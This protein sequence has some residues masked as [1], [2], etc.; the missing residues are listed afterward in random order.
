MRIFIVVL[1]ATLNVPAVADDHQKDK[2][3]Q[4]EENKVCF[5]GYKDHRSFLKD[6]VDYD[7]PELESCRKGDVVAFGYERMNYGSLI[8]AAARLCNL[9]ETHVLIEDARKGLICTFTG[10]VL[11]IVEIKK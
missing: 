7:F 4:K 3:L 6:K 1:L 10:K 9:S 11:P 8:A 5:L 2:G